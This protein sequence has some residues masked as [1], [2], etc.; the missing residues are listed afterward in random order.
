MLHK[1]VVHLKDVILD[2]RGMGYKCSTGGYTVGSESQCTASV[3]FLV[4]H[5]ETRSQVWASRASA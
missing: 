5:R 2:K 3:I 1:V 4:G